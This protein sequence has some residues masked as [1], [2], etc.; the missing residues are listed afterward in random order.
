[1]KLV[2][3]S[4]SPRRKR[5]LG[6]IVKRFGVSAANIG[7]RM[8]KGEPF[9]S[10]CMRLAKKKAAAV[11][12]KN[13]GAIVIG[14][15]TIA[16]RGKKN[17]RKTES[18]ATAKKVLSFLRGK[19]HYVITGVAVIFPSGKCVKYGVRA[20]VKMKKFGDKQ[21]A[22]YLKSGEWKGRAGCYDIS[23]KG[24]ALVEK[25]RGEKETVVGLPL[26]RL[27]MFLKN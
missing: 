7:E 27:R 18:E 4:A 19:T 6:K 10:A 12:S 26:R 9:S 21:M 25:V 8:G 20:S 16:Y 1:M 11:S 23:G 17:F 2:L 5:L 14:A 3:A 13:P 22:S 24:A 15:D